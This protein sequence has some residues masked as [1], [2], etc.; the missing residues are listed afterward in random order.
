MFTGSPGSRFQAGSEFG[1]RFRRLHW[2]DRE[3]GL[4]QRVAHERVAD[5]QALGK[6]DTGQGAEL[7]V[8]ALDELV[9]RGCRQAGRDG[10][11]EPTGVNWLRWQARARRLVS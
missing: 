4:E 2:L 7:R 3:S 5:D 6:A 8:A 11:G 1:S 10:A 9:E